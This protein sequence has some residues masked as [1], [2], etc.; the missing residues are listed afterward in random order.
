MCLM[1]SLIQF[2]QTLTYVLRSMRWSRCSLPFMEF[3]AH[4]NVHKS[5]SLVPL[6]SHVNPILSFPSYNSKAHFSIIGPSAGWPCGS[7]NVLTKKKKKTEIRK[8]KR[9]AEISCCVFRHLYHGSSV[10]ASK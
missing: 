6:L 4:Y 10:R 7:S 8:R 2:Y 1:V 9:Y 3:E 5:R